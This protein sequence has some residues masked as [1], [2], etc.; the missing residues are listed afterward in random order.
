MYL[1]HLPVP[2]GFEILLVSLDWPIVIKLGPT[3][4]VV[5][6]VLVISFHLLVRSTPIG[7]RL[8]GRRFPFR[9]PGRAG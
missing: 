9:W 2:V 5:G 4:V 6:A 7:Q 1:I 8:N 3:W